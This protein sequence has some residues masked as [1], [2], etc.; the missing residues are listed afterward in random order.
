MISYRELVASFR[1]LDLARTTP[2]IAHVSLPEIGE[3]NGGADTVLGALCAAFDELVMPAFT[4]RAQVI[5]EVGPADNGLVYGSGR[6]SNAS[7]QFFRSDMPVDWQLGPLPESLRKLPQARR[8]IHPLI[9]FTG[10]NLDSILGAQ[11]LVEPL[12]PVRLLTE[13]G[14]WV[15]LVG[16]DH[17]VNTSLHYAEKLAG[18]KQFLRW[19]LTPAGVVEC[20]NMPGCA[21]GFN[22]IATRLRGVTRQAQ[23]GE[24]FVQAVPLNDL[25]AI[26]R[27]WLEADPLAL[28]CEQADCA[29]CQAVRAQVVRV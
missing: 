19:A 7:A 14:G 1:A 9:S 22:A 26:A 25:V 10:I 24:S 28:L 15:L 16:V 23:L 13:A 8:S 18:R 6:L 11:S 27:Q 5:P 4:Y 2:G 29:S 3:V 21:Q 20:P 12:A 17:T